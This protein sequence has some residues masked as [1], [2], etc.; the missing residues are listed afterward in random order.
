MKVKVGDIIQNPSV[1]EDHPNYRSLVIKTG[2][3]L[4]SEAIGIYSK[5]KVKY[6]TSDLN[7]NFKVVGRG[8]VEIIVDGLYN[9]EHLDL[10]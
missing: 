8:H 10:A 6:Y 7:A 4:T 5:R 3:T 9:S 1:S 2:N